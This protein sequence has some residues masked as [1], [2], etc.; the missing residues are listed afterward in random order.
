MRQHSEEITFQIV[1]TDLL[2]NGNKIQPVFT[3][4]MM[5]ITEVQ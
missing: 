3:N 5:D 1:S 2:A 4:E